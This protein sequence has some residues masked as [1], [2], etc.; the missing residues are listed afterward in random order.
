MTARKRIPGLDGLRAIAVILVMLYHLVP[1]QLPGGYIGVDVFFVLSGFLITT[2]LLEEKA[3]TGRIDLRAFWRRR[4][5]RLLPALAVLIPVCSTLAWLAG[6]DVLVGLGRQVVG[7]LT[8]SSNW[9][10]IGADNSY[11]SQAMPDLFRNLWSLSVEEQ[12]Y[13]VWPLVVLALLLI[14]S[15][16]VRLILILAVAAVSATVMGLLYSPTTDATRVYFGTDTHSFGLA[17]GAALAVLVRSPG[18]NRSGG[19]SRAAPSWSIAGIAAV[20][21][22]VA[23][24]VLLPVNSPVTYRGGLVLVSM[25]TAVAIGGCL[26]AESLLGRILDTRVLRWVGRR[27]YGL[28]LWHWPVYVLLS[29]AIP[30][31]ARTGETGWLLGAGAFAVTVV[32]VAASYRFIEQPIL[33]NGF[34]RSTQRLWD[35]MLSSR[36]IRLGTA[37]GA[38]LLLTTGTMTVGAIAGDPGAGRAQLSIRAGQLAIANSAQPARE[39]LA[40]PTPQAAAAPSPSASSTPAEQVP[41]AE[42]SGEQV[43][44]IGDSVMLASAPELQAVLPG[45]AIDAVVSRQMW[46]AA[47]I[48][49]SMRAQGSLRHFVLIGLGTNGPFAQSTLEELRS[50]AGSGRQIVLVNVYAPRGYTDEVNAMLGQ[51]DRQHITVELADWH[52]A[53]SGRLDLLA[54]DQIH[55]GKAGGRIYADIVYQALQRLAAGGSAP[56]PR[57]PT[58]ERFH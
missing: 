33:R 32:V 25:L 26:G 12:F 48:M 43:S 57:H 40:R 37:A 18:G 30:G 51:F 31:L 35:R 45:I 46:Q 2:L 41:P 7:A 29:G 28:Y 55:P 17:A 15:R 4:A 5:R 50:I 34:R 53:I 58:A 14:P 16:R 21:G 8:F 23:V 56:P 27:S 24:A 52:D 13:L 44:A 49:R 54:G 39:A 1:G 3:D 38:L 36:V 22:L 20:A 9:L 19:P 11:F 6:G 42:L 10:A 47:A